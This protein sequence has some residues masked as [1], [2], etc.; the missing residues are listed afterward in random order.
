[1]CNQLKNLPEMFYINLLI[2]GKNQYFLC[3][4]KLGNNANMLSE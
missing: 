2:T 1:M 4:E 3:S